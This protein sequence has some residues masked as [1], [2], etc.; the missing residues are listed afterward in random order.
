MLSDP[1]DED[2]VIKTITPAEYEQYKSEGII[3]GGMIPKLDN[4]FN[5]LHCGVREVVITKASEL[6]RS[7]GTRISL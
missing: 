2:S 1:D 6:L 5:A 3:Q 7:S 4:A